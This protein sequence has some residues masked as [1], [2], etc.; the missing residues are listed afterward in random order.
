MLQGKKIILGISG[1]I[2]AY[3]AALIVRLLVKSGAEVK[4]VMTEDAKQFITPLTLAT[5]SGNPVLSTYFEP[6]SGTWHNHVELGLWADLMLVAPA[7]ANTLSKFANGLCDNLLS[8]VYLSARCPV[9]LAPAMDLDMWT[10]PATQKNIALLTGYGNRIIAP[11]KGE[12]ASGLHGEGR[13]AEPD[14]VVKFLNDFF[15]NGQ[16]GISAFWQGRKVMISAGPTYEPI[17]PVRFIGNR[18]SG[19]MGY[20][21]AEALSARGADVTLISGPTSLERPKGVRFIAIESAAEL[22]DAALKHFP[23]AE[24]AIM[25]A[26]VSDYTPAMVADK[27]IKK[28]AEEGLSLA[29][30]KTTDVLATLGKQK[31]ASQTLVGF[32]LETDN[33][34]DNALSKLHRKNLDLIVLNT[35]EDKGAGFAGDNNKVTLINRKEELST[36]PLKPKKEVALDILHAIEACIGAANR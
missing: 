28:Q 22:L 4:V 12:L 30:N 31:S 19:K 10:H 13:L 33:A 26:A 36:F 16:E 34:V 23:G 5:L 18:S 24:V 15:Q 17:D 11:G 29:L 35:L 25:S 8:A 27:K 20:A 9:L 3:K 7:T 14:K 6:D 21:L 2:A 1:S 32:A